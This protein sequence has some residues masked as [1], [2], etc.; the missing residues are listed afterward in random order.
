MNGGN[1][2]TIPIFNAPKNSPFT[3]KE[4]KKIITDTYNENTKYNKTGERKPLV[5][6]QVFEPQ[7]QIRKRE[8]D[9]ALYVPIQNANPL[10]IPPQYL[11]QYPYQY[12]PNYGMPIVKNYNIN[13]SGP[14]ADHGRVSTLFEDV[15][16]DTKTIGTY[17]TL[18]GRT[19]I[20]HYVRSIFIRHNDGEDID[21]NGTGE[22]SLLSYLKFMELNPYNTYH[23]SANPYKG[24][25]DDMLIYRSCYPIRLD[26]TTGLIQ[27]AKNSIGVNIRI[28][29]LTDK[30]YNVRKDKNSK[31]EDYDAWREV[32]YYEYIREEIIKKIVCPN[33]IT[34]YAYYI[35]ENCNVDFDKILKIKGKIR[36][37]TDLTKITYKPLT[38]SNI[39]KTPKNNLTQ[40]NKKDTYSGKGLV[41]LTES[42]TYNMYGWASRTYKI[43]GNVNT[44]INTGFHKSEVWLSILMQLMTALY[45]LQ[46]HDIAIE[47]FDVENNVYIKDISS[48]DNVTK[49]WKYIIDGFEFYVPNYGYI[50]LIDTNYRDTEYAQTIKKNSDN[51]YKIYGGIFNSIKPAVH[52]KNFENFKRCFSPNAYSDLFVSLGGT[53][54]PADI[55]GLLSEITT[56]CAQNKDQNISHYIKKYM[57]NYMNNRIGT[58]LTDV[59]IKNIKLHD[60]KTF[61]PGQIVVNLVSFRTYKFCIYVAEG[62]LKGQSEILSK[63][64]P[65]DKSIKNYTV[66]T[67]NI[68]IYSDV[69]PIIQNYKFNESNLSEDA[70]L[71]TYIIKKP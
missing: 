65:M 39:N 29:R 57:R 59:E 15:L 56:E 47:T 68:Y 23:F 44:M 26:R 58:Y 31:Y 11:P 19:N 25:P 6:V 22:N 28:Y 51:I 62:T 7:Q 40:N 69:N 2:K 67:D 24:L 61:L 4:H 3:S 42:P 37:D 27:C 12:V 43:S 10:T 38:T 5:D 8:I 14:S 66:S 54:P 35:C 64:N 32:S 21:I 13:V 9:P 49:Y 53:K 55:I 41:A 50:A 1:K 30:A 70:L 16:P 60:N 48:N 52:I 45:V 20:I 63:D 46:I 36:Q 17:N 71:E 18:G 33:F 34:M